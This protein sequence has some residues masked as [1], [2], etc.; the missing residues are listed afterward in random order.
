MSDTQSYA[1]LTQRGTPPWTC[2]ACSAA[3]AFEQWLEAHPQH[4]RNLL[5]GPRETVYSERLARY[6]WTEH[7]QSKDGHNVVVRGA[8]LVCH[9]D[10]VTPSDIDGNPEVLA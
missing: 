8:A 7:V 10:H 1:I 2:R 5:Y 3:H 4:E 6:V 9:S